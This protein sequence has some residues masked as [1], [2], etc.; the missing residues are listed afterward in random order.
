[1][2]NLRTS[3]KYSWISL[4]K[5]SMMLNSSCAK[6][7]FGLIL[8]GWLQT[9]FGPFLVKNKQWIWCLKRQKM[10]ILIIIM[11]LGKEELLL[12][13]T[14]NRQSLQHRISKTL[15]TV[16]WLTWI[17]SSP[18]WIFLHWSAGDWAQERKIYFTERVWRWKGRA[19]IKTMNKSCAWRNLIAVKSWMITGHVHK[20]Q[21]L[22]SASIWWSSLEFHL[23]FQSRI[24]AAI[25]GQMSCSTAFSW[26]A[27]T[28]LGHSQISRGWCEEPTSRATF[29]FLGKLVEFWQ[30]R[31]KCLTEISL[32]FNMIWQTLALNGDER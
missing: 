7:K 9:Q 4:H 30:P 12:F 15:T 16:W 32:E 23:P 10:I 24:P 3:R 2:R 29:C 1:M 6:C 14:G 31:S 27:T 25:C 22:F 20:E 5:K 18:A 26:A 17:T 21:C 13:T 8:L 19:G 11:K 28:L